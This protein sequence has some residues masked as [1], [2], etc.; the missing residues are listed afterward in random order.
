MQRPSFDPG[1]TQQYTDNIRRT[2]N[3]DGSFNVHRRGLSILRANIYLKLINMSWPAFFTLVTICFFTTNTIF[4]LLYLW[5][6]L[7]NLRGAELDTSLHEFTSAFFFSVHTLTTVGYGSMAPSGLAMNIVS[8][9]EAMTGL[10]GFA[11]ATG[12]LYGRFSRPSARLLYSDSIL[13]APYQDGISLQFRV[14]NLRN[15]VLMEL[16]ATALLMTVEQDGG[17]MKRN[18]RELSLERQRVFFL[19]LTWTIVHPID[20]ASPLHGLTKEDLAREQAEVIVLIKG[21]DDTFSQVVHSRRS[22]RHDEI[23]WGA[24]FVQIFSVDQAGDMVLELNRIDEH[25]SAQLPA[26]PSPQEKQAD[27]TC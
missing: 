14:A 13:M 26:L 8:A 18:F 19:P 17:R 24:K 20:S 4:A 22:Y 27:T 5:V 10:L 1:F 25:V 6:G 12:L 3:P 11:L 15:N 23:I 16:E 7:D 21:F 2:I 9:L